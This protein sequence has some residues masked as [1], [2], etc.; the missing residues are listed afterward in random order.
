VEHTT[1]THLE[2]E[3]AFGVHEIFF[4]ITEHDSTILSGNEVF[5][6]ISGYTKEELTG[7][8]HNL[9][10][11]P[12]M[13]RI[14]FKTLWEYLQAEK[15]IVAYVKNRTKEGD[16][17]WV[18]AAVFPLEERYVSIRI[19]PTTEL[20]DRIQELYPLLLDAE[21]HGGVERSEALLLTALAQQGYDDYTQ[22]MSDALLSELRQRRLLL[23][24]STQER[25]LTSADTLFNRHLHTIRSL[26]RSLIGTYDL[27][28]DKI[29]TFLEIKSTFEAKSLLLRH[30]ARDVVLLSLN[31]SVASYKVENGGETFGILARDVRTNAKENDDLIARIDTLV[32]TLSDSLNTLIFSVSGI[33]LQSEVLSYFINELLCEH[34]NTEHHEIEENMDTLIALITEYSDNTAT[35]Q[36]EIA[37]QVQ[38]ML[39][40]LDQLEK[41]IMYLGYIQVYGIIE[42]AGSHNETVSFEGIFS[43]LKTLIQKTSREVE[44]MQKMGGL[45][46]AENTYLINRSSAL[47]HHLSTLHEVNVALKAADEQNTPI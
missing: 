9:V 15:P 28:F 33:R 45:F 43:E 20:F 13:P 25:A 41:Q 3:A 5:V 6:Q 29:N 10:R 34:C 27:Y 44:E 12:D 46:Y 37:G 42:A 1:H 8:Y 21:T 18:L 40:H 16:Y 38:E 32:H 19:K 30:V 17:Y 23:G 24:A 4:S 36:R 47:A 7:R 2:N 39:K 11:H 22:F 35:L 14:L 26:A 31:A